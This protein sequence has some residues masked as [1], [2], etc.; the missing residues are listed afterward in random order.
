MARPD[1]HL[2]ALHN[3][4]PKLDSRINEMFSGNGTRFPYWPKSVLLPQAGW[5]AIAKEYGVGARHACDSDGI[6]QL[7]AEVSEGSRL[8][9]IATWKY[10]RDIYCFDKTIYKSLLATDVPNNIPLKI[11][12]RL[13]SWSIY[14]ELPEKRGL[15]FG[16]WCHLEYDFRDGSY[17][18]RVTPDTDRSLSSIPILLGD[19]SINDSLVALASASSLLPGDNEVL[20]DTIEPIA[21]FITQDIKPVLAMLMY[22]CSDAPDISDAYG[23]EYYPHRVGA[24]KVKGGS[25]IFMP[26]KTRIWHVGA[27]VG[28]AIRSANDAKGGKK[29]P[30]LRRAHWHGFWRGP[31]DGK[32]EF[33]YKWLPPIPVGVDAEDV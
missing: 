4:Y 15:D 13:P 18:L 10:S 17:E 27:S 12:K 1:I 23:G 31:R 16:Y 3:D 21:E 20:A 29:S 6:E 24:R 14:I 11:F 30:H 22:I 19:D 28:A 7:F 32:R 33:I 9:A 2:A 5:L 25:R 26:E 8:S